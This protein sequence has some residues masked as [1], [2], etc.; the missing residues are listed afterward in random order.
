MFAQNR[1]NLSMNFGKIA[2][3][4]PCSSHHSKTLEDETLPIFV[5][6]SR[7]QYPIVTLKYGGLGSYWDQTC[8]SMV[9][10]GRFI[11]STKRP[12]P[13][14]YAVYTVSSSTHDKGHTTTTRNAI[15]VL[16]TVLHS[17]QTTV[18]LS[19]PLPLP[20]P[21]RSTGGIRAPSIPGLVEH[22]A[23]AARRGPSRARWSHRMRPSPL[24]SS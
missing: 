23:R 6:A 19:V 20:L 5:E 7:Q 12:V 2:Q 4:P 11:F 18:T 14:S 17:I 9:R 21:S 10:A 15:T 8:P 1:R 24:S 22:G 16:S 3:Y 13:G